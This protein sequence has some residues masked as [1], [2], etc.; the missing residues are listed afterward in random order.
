[1]PVRDPNKIDAERAIRIFNEFRNWQA[2]K[3]LLKRPNGT[4]YTM[5]AICKAVRRHDTQ[6]EQ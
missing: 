5:D 3:T 6:A 1:M 2:V 4:R